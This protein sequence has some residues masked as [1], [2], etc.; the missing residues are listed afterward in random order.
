MILP[1]GTGHQSLRAS[2][3]L[4]VVGAYPPSGKYAECR[5]TKPNHR[6]ALATIPRVPVPRKDPVYGKHGPLRTLWVK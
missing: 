2:D 6:R 4:L 5:P 1:A 3:N